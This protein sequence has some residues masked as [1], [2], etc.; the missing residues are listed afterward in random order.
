MPRTWFDAPQNR[1]AFINAVGQKL[2]PGLSGEL[3]KAAASTNPQE[4]DAAI[5]QLSMTPKVRAAFNPK[6]TRLTMNR[7]KRFIFARQILGAQ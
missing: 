3:A 1:Q 2:G 6:T 5:S 7:T 4:W